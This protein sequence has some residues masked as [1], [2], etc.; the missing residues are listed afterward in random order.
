MR[1]ARELE[2]KYRRDLEVYEKIDENEAVAKYGT[3]PVDTK[4]VDT[5]SSQRAC[6]MSCG[7]I[8]ER[9]RQCRRL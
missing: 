9:R 6:E 1:E 3:T 8:N 4:W 7:Q 2:L 5:D